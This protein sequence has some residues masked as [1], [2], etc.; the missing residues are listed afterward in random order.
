[1]TELNCAI[2]F[3]NVSSYVHELSTHLLT[4]A[5]I[6]LSKFLFLLVHISAD[7]SYLP[8]VTT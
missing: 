2:N 5:D 1:M 8:V 3:I 4:V 7:S 6:S